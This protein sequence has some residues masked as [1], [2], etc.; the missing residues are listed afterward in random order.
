MPGEDEEVMVQARA[1]LL[2]ALGALGAHADNV[3]VIGAQA[4][5]LHTGKLEL[6][7]AEATKDADLAIDSRSLSDDPL[8]EEAMES[9]GFYPDPE[10]GQPGAWRSPSGMPVDLMVPEALAGPAKHGR[11]GGRI[12]PHGHRATRRAVGLEAAVVDNSEIEVEALGSGDSRVL[13]ARV[14]GPAAL[15]VAKLHK[16]GER[17]DAPRRLNAK[18][19]HDIYR[20]FRA[21]STRDLARS[22]D[23]LL[24]EEVSSIVT[25]Q[26]L[27]Y[28]ER[29]FV[30]A[31]STGALLAGDAE[32]GVGDPDQV[33]EAVALL[34][35]DL[36]DAGGW[37]S[38]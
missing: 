34:A 11:R 9:A 20:L 13:V 16:I 12:R 37:W 36:L 30:D 35:G 15:I 10:S 18:D 5:Y 19:A 28:L 22:V 7:L 1:A 17:V 25:R 2:E 32:V 38:K 14:A 26:A 3:V 27:K 31:D 24:D 6:A 4:V 8:L 21:V 29:F 33:S 23:A